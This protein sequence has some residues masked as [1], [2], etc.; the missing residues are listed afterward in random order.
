MSAKEATVSCREGTKTRTAG[1]RL[2]ASY[3]NFIA[4]GGVVMPP[5]IRVPTSAAS[6]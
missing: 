4:N 2:A 6:A 3:V 5:S 1:E